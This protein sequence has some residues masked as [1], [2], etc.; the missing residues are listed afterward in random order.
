MVVGLLLAAV[1][2]TAADLAGRRPRLTSTA[3]LLFALAAAAVVSFDSLNASSRVLGWPYAIA[4]LPGQGYYLLQ[5]GSAAA[6]A[7]SL[8]RVFADR[9][10]WPFHRKPDLGLLP[11]MKRPDPARTPGRELLQE[12]RSLTEPLGSEVTP[13]VGV[14]RSLK[15]R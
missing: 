1:M 12:S 5:A 10:R 6:A 14:N 13:G 8:L 3:A 4:I 7:L 9:P 2:A 11:T 15:W